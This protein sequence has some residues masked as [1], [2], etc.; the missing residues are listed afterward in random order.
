MILLVDL[1]NTRVKWAWLEPAGQG[2][3]RAEAYAGWCVGDWR[4]ELFAGRNA[5][6][7]VACSVASA[8]AMDALRDAAG[9]QGVTRVE[10]VTAT[11]QAAGVTNG[12]DEPA[13]L[14]ADRWV[15]VIGAFHERRVDTC[16]VNVGTAMTVD[17]VTA[18]GLHLGGLIVPGPDLM[19]RSL[20]LETSDLAQRSAASRARE[21]VS[22]AADTRSAIES[23]CEISL[24]AL[25]D[26]QCGE[27]ERQVGHAPR[28][29][30][31][32]GA[33]ERVRG[34][35]RGSSELVPDLVLRGLAVIATQPTS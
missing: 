22:F 8:A 24:A 33:A 20:H 7:V 4:R 13:Q 27:L 31:A 29:L 14:G 18:N 23:G 30:L 28:L 19:V 32:G 5:A 1:G 9:L 2:A 35:I 11:R 10:F 12:Y 17:A 21:R 6:R 15:A 26:R 25:I 3:M 34:W 16:I